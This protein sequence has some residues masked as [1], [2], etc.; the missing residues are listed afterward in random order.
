[1]L[2]LLMD[3]VID[4]IECQLMKM[5]K[6]NYSHLKYFKVSKFK[7][8]RIKTKQKKKIEIKATNGNEEKRKYSNFQS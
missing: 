2:S 1:M 4:R 3:T 6:K 5:K 7:F 8:N